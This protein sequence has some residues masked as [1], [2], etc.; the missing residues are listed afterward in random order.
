MTKQDLRNM[1]INLLDDEHG[2]NNEGHNGLEQLCRECGWEDINRATELQ[3][4]RAF[5]FE[6]DAADLR[7]VEIGGMDS[8]LGFKVVK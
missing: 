5:M 4:D 3:E 8:T 1:I 7:K 2:V 6:E